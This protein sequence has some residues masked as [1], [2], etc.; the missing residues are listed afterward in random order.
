MTFLAIPN[1]TN[2]IFK[3]TCQ[4]QY[5][6]NRKWH[7]LTN[8]NINKFLIIIIFSI[9]NCKTNYAQQSYIVTEQYNLIISQI[10]LKQ[11]SKQVLN[12]TTN[13][14]VICAESGYKINPYKLGDSITYFSARPGSSFDFN[15]MKYNYSHPADYLDPITPAIATPL[16]FYKMGVM[17]DSTTIY[18]PPPILKEARRK[19][20]T[21]YQTDGRVLRYMRTVGKNTNGFGFHYDNKGRPDTIGIYGLQPDS[22]A[23]RV[24]W[25]RFLSYDNNDNV[26]KDSTY[27]LVAGNLR[28]YAASSYAY[29]TNGNLIRFVGF[30]FTCGF[31]YYPDNLLKTALMIGYNSV[32]DS[33]GYQPGVNFYTYRR[34]NGVETVKYLNSQN[35]PDTVRYNDGRAQWFLSYE[36]DQEG[37]PTKSFG[38]DDSSGNNRLFSTR[39][40]YYTA[41]TSVSTV[42]ANENIVLFPNPAGDFISLKS[43]VTNIRLLSVQIFNTS[44]QLMQSKRI[45]LAGTSAQID[46]SGQAPGL[47]IIKVTDEQGNQLLNTTFMKK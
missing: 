6:R 41:A 7:N 11:S 27:E 12:K 35:L 19:I 42:A 30:G 5:I 21:E 44:G 32:E 38:Y 45:P 47:Y 25:K 31:T 36:Y 9:S 14:S 13:S 16:I 22:L 17:S 40:Y 8:M 28:P 24:K 3:W 29:D 26:I 18:F 34:R 20:V 1:S 23:D 33:F 2:L 39:N 43:T 10:L 46:V 15:E 4:I 37:R